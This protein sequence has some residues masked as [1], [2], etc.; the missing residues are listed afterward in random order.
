[1]SQLEL[2]KSTYNALLSGD[3]LPE[4]VAVQTVDLRA[5]LH[6]SA[7]SAHKKIGLHS[8]TLQEGKAA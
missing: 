5:L 6:A 4:R 1:M 2:I 3:N 7:A 8:N